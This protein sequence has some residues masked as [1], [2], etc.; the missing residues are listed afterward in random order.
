MKYANIALR[1]LSRQKRR[2]ILIAGAVALGVFIIL[3]VNAF[4]AGSVRILKENIA[5]MVG[6]H[7]FISME[8]RQENGKVQS[9]IIDDSKLVEIA[10]GLGSSEGEI[11]RSVEASGTLIHGGNSVLMPNMIGVDWQDQDLRGLDRQ[12]GIGA[13]DLAAIR[14]DKQALIISRRTAS[15]LKVDLGDNVIFRM[16]TISGQYNVGDF[17]V[18]F[19]TSDDSDVMS[20]VAFAYQ[21]YIAG[22]LDLPDPT[23]YTNF[24]IKLNSIDIAP[25]YAQL[26]RQ[27]AGAIYS[28]KDQVAPSFDFSSSVMKISDNVSEWTGERLAISTVNEMLAPMTSLVDGIFIISIAVFIVLMLITVIGISNTFRMILLER[29]GEIGTMRALGIQRPKVRSLILYEAWFLSLVGF[30]AG[31]GLSLVTQGLLSLINFGTESA[32]TMFLLNGHLNFRLELAS[33]VPVLILVSGFT[34]LAA[35]GPARKAAK[36]EPAQA[37]RTVN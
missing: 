37:L 32:M 17:V 35:W 9:Y 11:S 7:V 34:V 3:T 4:S 1:N 26:F 21:S 30:G 31:L 19:I 33:L 6:G 29:V 36:L 23:A 12:L 8:R 15:R 2:S 16:Q 18:R 27:Q 28:L 14:A 10:K 13:T 22:L 20:I 24:Q 25:V 5:N